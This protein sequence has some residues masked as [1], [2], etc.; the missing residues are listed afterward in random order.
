MLMMDFVAST[1]LVLNNFFQELQHEFKIT[2]K[3]AEYYLGVE[4]KKLKTGDTFC[5]QNYTDEVLEKFN[6]KD[7]NPVSIYME[8]GSLLE[9]GTA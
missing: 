9:E 2:Y 6:V 4:I 1:P 5:Q 8:K 7:A 3:D